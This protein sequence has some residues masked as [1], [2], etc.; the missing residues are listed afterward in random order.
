M[1]GKK[2]RASSLILVLA[3]IGGQLRRE[4]HEEQE[5]NDGDHH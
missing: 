3:R 1:S 4:R 5:A 2:E